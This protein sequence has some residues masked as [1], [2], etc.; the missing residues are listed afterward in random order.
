MWAAAGW[1]YSSPIPVHFTLRCFLLF[2]PHCIS[3]YV[4]TAMCPTA[5]PRRYRSNLQSLH[6]VHCDLALR[7][8]YVCLRVLQRCY[9][10]VFTRRYRANLVSLRVV[11]CDLALRAAFWAAVRWWRGGLWA[12]VNFVSRVEF[13]AEHFAQVRGKGKQDSVYMN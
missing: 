13:L 6:V 2:V 11:H 5:F 7:V 3:F 4:V 9:L 10:P 8:A 1:E 12:K